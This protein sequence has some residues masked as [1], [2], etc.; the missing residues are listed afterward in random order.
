MFVLAQLSFVYQSIPL[1]IH[2]LQ[3]YT[4]VCNRQTFILPPDAAGSPNC[5]LSQ[6]W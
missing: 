6:G 3:Y 4:L 5:P 2:E 1:A